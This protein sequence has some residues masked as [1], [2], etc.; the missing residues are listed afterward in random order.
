MWKF[1]ILFAAVGA[2]W[3]MWQRGNG[4]ISAARY[5]YESVR[6]NPNTYEWLSRS[7]SGDRIRDT[8]AV[9]RRFGLSQRYA[10]ALL[11]EFARRRT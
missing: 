2:A 8:H 3:L 6:S 1:V 7:L 11:D 9:R 4:S 10:Q 5:L